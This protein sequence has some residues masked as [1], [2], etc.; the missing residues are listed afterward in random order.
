[1]E[2]KSLKTLILR[3][4]ENEK[5]R[6]EEIDGLNREV[7]EPK[8]LL[9]ND[10]AGKPTYARALK[11]NGQDVQA[12][13][14]NPVVGPVT[15]HHQQRLR[16]EDDKRSITINTARFKGEKTNFLQI[17]ASLQRSIDNV[18]LLQG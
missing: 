12:T 4:L 15:P 7:Q 6:A 2:V 16:V 18:P 8:K 14:V 11:A 13:V 3:L 1:D 5:V 17:K 10:D 9:R